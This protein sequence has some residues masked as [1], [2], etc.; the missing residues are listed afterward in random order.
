MRIGIKG[1]LIAKALAGAALA[2]IPAFQHVVVI[3]QEN[4]TPDNLFQGL[5]AAPFGSAQSCSATPG[6]SQ[7]NIQTQA[8]FDNS[9]SAGVTQPAPVALAN[10]YDL[11]HAHS[12]FVRQCDKDSL[13][14]VCRMDGSAGVSCSGTCLPKPQFRF[15]D[16][17]AG[18][19]SPYLRLATQYG[20]ANYMFQ[21]NQG[22]SFPAHQFI[23]GGTSAPSAADDAAGVFASG[24]MSG[25]GN[26]AGCAAPSGTTVQLI[27][28]A[29]ETRKVYP[30]FE[31][32]TMPDVLPRPVTWR[33]Y[34]PG[35]GS[36]WTA[37]NAIQHICQSTGPGGKCAGSDWTAN[38]D[39]N[40]VDVLK[41]ISQCNLRSISWVIPSGVNSDHARSNDG[42]GPSWVASIVNAI[43]DSAA[44]D[45][46]TGYWQNTAIVITWDD[47]GGWYDHEPPTIL[48]DP[49]GDYQ[50]GFRVP[51]VF[52]SAYTP[53]GYIDNERHDFGSILRFVEHNFGITEGTL[54]FADARAK[55]DLTR[56]YD[57]ARQ[58]R[59]FQSIPSP[60]TAEFFLKDKRRP[61]APDN[62]GDDR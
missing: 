4:R 42:G 8:W 15:V 25:A 36:I 51:L 23:F 61:T 59:A 26:V 52:V 39:L 49:Q 40:P 5:C 50:Y 7:Y 54:N 37:P 29:G 13:T 20:W 6:P 11:S 30:C 16:N 31:H 24:N 22:P 19:V 1:L 62:D 33:Y 45:N 3:F 17:A 34:T 58:A 9:S 21:T 35:A 10:R 12:A 47:W 44:C 41:D 60:K 28:P 55:N 46:H 43:G 38:V 2:Q 27:A 32:S 14:G 18:T 56:F 53:A 48:G 57:L